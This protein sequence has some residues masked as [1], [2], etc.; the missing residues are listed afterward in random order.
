MANNQRRPA[1]KTRSGFKQGQE[2]K[3]GDLLF[4]IDP[5]P[6][7]AIVQRAE[8]VLAVAPTIAGSWTSRTAS[9]C[10]RT[11]PHTRCDASG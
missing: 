3:K 10:R 1:N 8:A 9:G 7:E 4:T 11:I 6:Y 2:V 5:R